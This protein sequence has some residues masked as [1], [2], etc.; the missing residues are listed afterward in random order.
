VLTTKTLIIVPEPGP[1]PAM[2]RAYDKA[3]G[4]EVGAVALPA[5][6]TGAPMTYS[7]DG[8]QYVAVAVGGAGY[9]G[10]LLVFR[11]PN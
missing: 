9:P 5:P 8:R 2:M 10:E 3:T 7:I 4:K 11:L 1:S 6:A